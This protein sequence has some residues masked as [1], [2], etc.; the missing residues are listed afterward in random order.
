MNMI[1]CIFLISIGFLNINC[2]TA[3]IQKS[4][5][6][7]NSTPT[8]EALCKDSERPETTEY[9]ELNKSVKVMYGYK[10]AVADPPDE[11]YPYECGLRYVIEIQ[12]KIENTDIIKKK[13]IENQICP[14][15]QNCNLMGDYYFYTAN[16]HGSKL[17]IVLQSYTYENKISYRYRLDR[18]LEKIDDLNESTKNVD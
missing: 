11:G 4:N 9:M 5:L 10:F 12:W 1:R 7:Q 17:N 8:I 2:S 14:V 15:L 6:H 13:V 16:L 3:I 18:K